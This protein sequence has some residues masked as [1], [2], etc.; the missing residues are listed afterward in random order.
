M[1]WFTHA[2]DSPAN[3]TAAVRV[4]NTR[5]RRPKRLLAPSRARRKI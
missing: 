5:R 3:E 4:I 1:R 2:A